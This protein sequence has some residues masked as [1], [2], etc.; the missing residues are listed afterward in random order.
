LT[1]PADA[2]FSMLS[3]A[4]G[5]DLAGYRRDHIEGRVTRALEREHAAN[6]VELVRIL[7]GDP[8]ARARFRRSI[9]ISTS[10]LFRDR[11]QFDVLEQ[12]VLPELLER[13]RRLHVWSAGCAD[14][15]ELY[16]IGILLER[17]GALERSTLLGS[18]VLE[19]NIALARA[20]RYGEVVIEPEI[21]AR[22]R[23]ECR[24]LVRD[25]PP[26]GRWQLVVCRNLAIYLSDKAKAVLHRT[27]SDALATD[28]VLLLGRSE[29][30]LRPAD[31]GL[32]RIGPRLYRRQ[33]A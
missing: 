32:V 28:G 6:T 15:S 3:L 11:G 9:A 26:A 12:Q 13:H 4:I 2:T 29:R 17:A 18:D 19:E 33:A 24:D 7:R 21:R 22:A 20:A 27:L 25:G 1:T 8:A 16:T 5:I 23:W 30:V 14:G 31:L 10:G